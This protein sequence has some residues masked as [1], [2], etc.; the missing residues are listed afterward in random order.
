[1]LKAD[2]TRSIAE[3]ARSKLERDMKAKKELEERSAQDFHKKLLMLFEC[4]LEGNT[5]YFFAE[6]EFL[7][8]QLNMFSKA[9]FN[10]SC[11]KANRNKEAKLLFK[12]NEVHS[13]LDKLLN[14]LTD[15]P[16]ILANVFPGYM[17]A[18]SAFLTLLNNYW[19][20]NKLNKF[21]GGRHFLSLLLERNKAWSEEL[22]RASSLFDQ[23]VD[24][25]SRLKVIELEFDKISSENKNIPEGVDSGMLVSWDSSAIDLDWNNNTL[26]SPPGLSWISSE[27]GQLFIRKLGE[28]I[29]NEARK[30]N[31]EVL[32]EL[33]DS[34]D[35][36]TADCFEDKEKK[37]WVDGLGMVHDDSWVDDFGEVHY[38]NEEGDEFIGVPPPSIFAEI[39]S[40]R[41][42]KSEI[43]WKP[44]I[45]N[46]DGEE[47]EDEDEVWDAKIFS[48]W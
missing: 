38:K 9:G 29:S 31:L 47:E 40:L 37:Y 22:F 30:G 1:M 39:L 16:V 13:I 25:F 21:S 20:S 42:Y 8:V 6:D 43:T 11:H 19:G 15:H 18:P 3:S 46:E 10:V 27:N 7:N 17:A 35:R 5:Q 23:I 41:G 33:Y 36:W 45:L 4:A 24:Y 48:A 14:K 12:L 28:L 44:P 26:L 32:W 34:G 2:H